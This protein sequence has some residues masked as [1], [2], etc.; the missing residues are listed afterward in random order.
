MKGERLFFN[1]FIILA[2]TLNFG[3]F[4]GD[5]DNPKHHHIYELFGAIIV[6]LIAFILKIGDRSQMGAIQLATSLVVLL[7]LFAAAIVWWWADLQ[8]GEEIKNQIST[9]VSLS[10]GALVANIISGILLVMDAFIIRR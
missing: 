6:S 2:L 9:I 3:F 5:M 8:D 4:L 10:G 1:F 7:H